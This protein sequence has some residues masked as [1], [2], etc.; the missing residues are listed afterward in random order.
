[1]FPTLL[2]LLLLSPI[3][4]DSPQPTGTLQGVVVNGTQG[5]E[6]ISETTIVLRAGPDG[7]LTPVAETRTDIYGKFVFEDVPLDPSITYLPGAERD[8]VHYPGQRMRLDLNN[9]FAHQTITA[10]D[11]VEAPSPLISQ[12]YTI[13][14]DVRQDVM[15]VNETILVTNPSR[16]TYVGKL[17]D[18][19]P[20]TLRLAV[21][22]NF[23]RVTFSNEF[24][25]R[26]F[27]IVE[28]QPVIDIPWPP[29]ERELKFAYRIPLDQT[30][31]VFC[32]ALD[33]PC[34]NVTLRVRGKH[35]REVSCN[36][37]IAKQSNSEI[38]FATAVEELPRGHV[39]EL[40]VGDLPFQWLRYA[41]PG[42]LV[43]LA[44]L[45]MATV[46]LFRRRGT[47]NPLAERSE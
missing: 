43:A 28:H 45:M 33:M 37:A 26:R 20:V 13:E 17:V 38:V 31:G 30:V 29:G 21:P 3:V 22:P 1:M 4:D 16:V 36:L 9:R 19:L 7:A 8:G 14:V 40:Q 32:R 27:R 25:G 35:A 47:I 41:R 11:A 23:D 10:F 44:A 5:D 6:P 18:E 12:R 34:R 39:I 24:Y 42:S 15:E 2:A 46:V